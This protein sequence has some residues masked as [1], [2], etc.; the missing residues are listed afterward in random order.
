MWLSRCP[1]VWGS[2]PSGSFRD[3]TGFLYFSGPFGTALARVVMYFLLG[4]GL[5]L[6][7]IAAAPGMAFTAATAW[8]FGKI[9]T[10]CR[11]AVRTL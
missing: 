6:M 1:S 11:K 4:K 10:R 2:V 5:T 3:Q 8:A 7:L 9:F